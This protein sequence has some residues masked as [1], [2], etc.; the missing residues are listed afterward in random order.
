MLGGIVLLLLS[1]GLRELHQPLHPTLR[2]SLALAYLIIFGS[3]LGF[4]AFVWLL[5]KFP[6]ARVSS[7]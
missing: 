5:T 4:T 6:A 1:A 7:Q 2:A 3:L